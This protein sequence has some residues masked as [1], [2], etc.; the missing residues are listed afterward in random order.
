MVSPNCQ[1]DIVATRPKTDG[2][3]GYRNITPCLLPARPLQRVDTEVDSA[4]ARGNR[5]D[6]LALVSI[7]KGTSLRRQERRHPEA[8]LCA[9]S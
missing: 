8:D 4:V 2:Y 6:A 9:Q 5:D 1:S 3:R 7:P